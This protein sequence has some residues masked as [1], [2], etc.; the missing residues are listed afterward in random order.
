PVSFPPISIIT[1]QAPAIEEHIPLDLY[2]RIAFTT[3]VGKVSDFQLAPDGGVVV[4]VEKQ[5]PINEAVMRADM[6]TYTKGMRERRRYEAF[7]LWAN[8][9]L[10][11][12]L[13]DT[14]LGQ[15][16]PAPP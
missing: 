8:R 10:A 2:K 11:N 6:P 1:N 3:P 14:P 9:E 7:V 16:K 5:L 13:R 12:A 4:Y 15:Q